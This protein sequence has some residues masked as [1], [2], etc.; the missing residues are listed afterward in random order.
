MEKKQTAVEWFANQLHIT[1][2]TMLEQAKEMEDAT[3]SR[4]ETLE[5][6]AKLLAKS[7]HYNNWDWETP[8]ERVMEML[9]VRLGY[10]PIDDEDEVIIKTSV[11]QDLYRQ[12]ID[13]VPLRNHRKPT[14]IIKTL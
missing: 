7:W 9:M 10:Y 8:N 6:L 3:I 5:T 1:S 14:P 4:M 2:G 12:S 11:D 13:E